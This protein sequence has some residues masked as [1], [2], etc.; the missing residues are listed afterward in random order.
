MA[1]FGQKMAAG[2]VSINIAPSGNSGASLGNLPS[3][4]GAQSS[5]PAPTAAQVGAFSTMGAAAPIASTNNSP[6]PFSN[7][8]ANVPVG[9]NTGAATSPYIGTLGANGV[10]AGS[11]GAPTQTAQSALTMPPGSP[12]IGGA[13]SSGFSITPAASAIT[14]STPAFTSQ[15][16]QELDLLNIRGLGFARGGDIKKKKLATGGIPNSSELD[17]WYV[18]QDERSMMHPEGMILGGAGGRTDVH[19]INVPSGAYVI[20]ADV[21]SGLGEGSTMAGSGVI[22]RMMHSAPGGINMSG[23]RH[24]SGVG[25]PRAPAPFRDSSQALPSMQARGGSAKKKEPSGQPVPIIVAG[26]EH[27]LWPQ[28]LIKKFGSLDRGHR[29]LDK[30]VLTARKKT[31][32]DMRKLKGPKQ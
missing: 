11:S 19:N 26:G 30:F 21:V 1:A 13:G 16:Q 5:V 12:G 20:P 6:Q 32:D 28:T 25:I 29:I 15:D 2:G 18:R 17:P 9:G 8:V 27:I 4:T 23:G 14:P 31:I 10:P 3:F 24:G 7:A 22:D